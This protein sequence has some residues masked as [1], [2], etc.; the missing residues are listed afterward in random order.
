[1]ISLYNLLVDPRG[2]VELLQF[3]LEPAFTDWREVDLLLPDSEA[4][5][6]VRVECICDCS[7][8]ELP[9]L[10]EEELVCFCL[11]PG[12]PCWQ[13]RCWVGVCLPLVLAFPWRS[14]IAWD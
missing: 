10:V 4:T 6:L 12:L 8:S 5:L 11:V 3:V 14:G 1:M 2:I 9:L 13:W 7:L